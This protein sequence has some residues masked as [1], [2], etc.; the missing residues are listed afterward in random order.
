MPYLKYRYRCVDAVVMATSQPQVVVHAPDSRGLR[1]V[2]VGGVSV[3]R[4]WSTRDLRRVLRRAGLPADIDLHHPGK[5]RWRADAALWPDRTWLRLATA[6][7]MALGIVTSAAVLF[8]VGLSDTLRALTF[9]GRVMGVVFLAGALMEVAAA[10]AVVDYWG[11]RKVRYSGPCVVLGVVIATATSAMLLILQWE[12]GYL[13][14][15]FWLWIALVAWSGWAV[16][17]LSRQKAW[18]G[19][20]HPKRFAVS[21]ALSALVGAAST[22]YSSMYSP[23]VAPPKVPFSVSF[24]KPNL[25]AT[26]STLYV[27]AQ[28]T[29]R[30]EGSVSIFVIGTLWKA[31]LWPS[32]FTEK[33]TDF[34]TVKNELGDG[35]ETYRHETFQGISRLLAAGQ[36]SPPGSRL[37]PGD[38]F[39]KN[40]VIEVPLKAGDGRLYLSASISFIRAD[41]GKLANSYPKSVE[42][43]WNTRS[44]AKEH[45]WDAP[46]WLAEK[47]DEFFRYRS[48]IYRTST[49]MNMT[50]H[51][52]WVAMWWVIPKSNKRSWFAPGD[53]DPK[54]AVHIA[55]DPNSEEQLSDEQQEPYGM[56]T[57]DDYVDRPVALLRQLAE[58]P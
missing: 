11:K 17:E 35:V 19:V 25:N 39:S 29:F 4:A 58:K 9:S 10:A 14:G 23:Y 32:T 53:T 2:S 16:W 52:D 15:W 18:Q 26:H 24:G 49:I 44:A 31:N 1:E 42:H 55:R 33:V 56:K 27:P 50:Q 5:V 48:R 21:L 8:R 46:N 13:H 41:R 54:M 51:P 28:F 43:S 34:G 12:G 20:P 6:C 30:N 40:V 22:A 7:L 38:D 45:Q 47:G 57:L 36:I 37:D 3:G